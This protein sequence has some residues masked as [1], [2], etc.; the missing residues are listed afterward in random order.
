VNPNQE[1]KKKEKE[2]ID[3]VITFGYLVQNMLGG[4]EELNAFFLGPKRRL[5]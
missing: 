5:R 4:I 1:L 2:K 3:K